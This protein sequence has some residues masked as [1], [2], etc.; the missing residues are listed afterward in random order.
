MLLLMAR[1]LATSGFAFEGDDRHPVGCRY[2]G[3]C[4][5][6]QYDAFRLLQGRLRIAGSF[7]R[8]LPFFGAVSAS[9]G[10]CRLSKMDA[11]AYCKKE[12]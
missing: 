6:S 2:R 8:G 11:S 7:S 12:A 4:R 5:F 3:D 1:A 10:V 9:G